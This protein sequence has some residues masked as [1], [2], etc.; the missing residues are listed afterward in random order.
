VEK[1]SPH[2]SR[3]ATPIKVLR[4]ISRLNIGGPSIH[5]SLLLNRLDPKSFQTK[6]VLGS[7]APSEGDMSYL[8]SDSD[9]RVLKIPELQREISPQKDIVAF[10]K[11]LK[12]LV[13]EK[14]SIVHTHMAKAG[15]IG[16]AAA[17][18]YGVLFNREI[19]L[20]HTYHG[21]VLQGYF[22]PLKSAVFLLIERILARCSDA[23]IALSASQRRELIRN[24]KIA[25]KE[26]VH[27]IPLGFDLSP[28]K[29]SFGK[30]GEFRRRHGLDDQ[31]ILIGIVG[32]LV[33]IKNHRL[34]LDAAR[35]L[36]D[37]EKA[38]VIKFLI[39]GDGEL[40]SELVD[41]AKSINVSEHVLFLGWQKELAAIYADLN[42]VALTSNNEGTPVSIIEAMASGVSVI[43]TC[44][45][46]VKDLMGCVRE[47]VDALGGRFWVHERGFVCDQ[48]DA[49]GLSNGLRFL[50]DE[51]AENT[52][53]RLENARQQVNRYYSD[54]LLISRIESLYHRLAN[55][56]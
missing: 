28:F 6:L 49:A 42:I 20:V 4:I 41:Y 14:P 26:K 15:A 44:V 46:G 52:R 53:Q 40:R 11:L 9:H 45:G 3:N 33:P 24:Y 12:I 19:R 7:L 30:K 16:R 39:I 10:L 55:G 2:R 17:R 36:L 13:R 8:L 21:H 38:R 54:Q 18:I 22:G 5:V 1:N 56:E 29:K 48:D 37:T 34:F 25:T 32:R 27:M 35:I 47:K 51:P 50:L 43:S 23:V 31:T